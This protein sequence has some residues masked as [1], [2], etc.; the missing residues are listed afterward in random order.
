MGHLAA[1]FGHIG[2]GLRLGEPHY[3]Y[4]GMMR[5]SSIEMSKNIYIMSMFIE[6]YWVFR[7]IFGHLNMINLLEK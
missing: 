7:S 5:C 4:Q 2:D 6:G 1:M 3:L